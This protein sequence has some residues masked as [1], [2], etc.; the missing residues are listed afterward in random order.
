MRAVAEKRMP[1]A[2]PCRASVVQ[3]LDDLALVAD[4][5]AGAF[6]GF[7]ELRGLLLGFG[8]FGLP[9]WFDDE[10]ITRPSNA[11]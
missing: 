8:H 6:Q 11:R 9:N 5:D 10:Q 7:D 1:S 3:A 4:E 2:R